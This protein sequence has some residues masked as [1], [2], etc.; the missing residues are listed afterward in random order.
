MELDNRARAAFVAL[1][2]L[3]LAAT[4]LMTVRMQ[5][6]ASPPP[7]SPASAVD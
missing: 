7:D 3:F 2:A 5:A 4:L 1:A 6:S